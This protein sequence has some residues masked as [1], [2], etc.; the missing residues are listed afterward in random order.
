MG[1]HTGQPHSVTR[2][3]QTS[4]ALFITGAVGSGKSTVLDHLG[5]LLEEAGA[6]FTLVDL[7]WLH[8]TWPPPADD[9]QQSQLELAN[10]Q[11]LATNV[12]A[13][14]GDRPAPSGSEHRFV[15]AGVLVDDDQRAA[16]THALARPMTVVRLEVE[17]DQLERQLRTR[18]TDPDRR[19]H[20]EWHLGVAAAMEE[21]LRASS[22]ADHVVPVAGRSP[23]QVASAVLATAGW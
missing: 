7:D 22:V 5:D 21:R 15:L 14:Q 6:P 17:P 8:R 4:R 9:P 13:A 23:R 16:V 11:S 19:R 20:L 3:D 10:L 1:A 2:K 12:L 18:Y